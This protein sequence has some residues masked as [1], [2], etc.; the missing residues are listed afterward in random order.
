MLD[1]LIV[2]LGIVLMLLG[3]AGSILPMLPG[4]PLNFAGL[5]LLAVSRH[6]S[7][8]LTPALII[9]LGIVMVLAAVMDHIIPLMGARKYGASKWG[10][11]GSV[12]GMLIGMFGSPLAMLAGGFAGAVI[13]EWFAHKKKKEALKAGWGVMV[14]TLFATILRLGVAGIMTYYFFKAIL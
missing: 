10:I 3:L 9:I 8:P 5:L 7:P 13:A 4:P 11:W 1:A 6:F 12:L 2:V 14:G